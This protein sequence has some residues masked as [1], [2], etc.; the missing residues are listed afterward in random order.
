MKG[1]H[2]GSKG[3]NPYRVVVI[4]LVG[5]VVSMQARQRGSRRFV[6]VHKEQIHI[7]KQSQKIFEDHFNDFHLDF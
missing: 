6:T 7:A 3:R 1:R 4:G 2:A 5:K